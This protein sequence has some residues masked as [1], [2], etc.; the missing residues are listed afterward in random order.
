VGVS[1]RRQGE[2]RKL[3]SSATFGAFRVGPSLLHTAQLPEPNDQPAPGTDV[4]QDAA[5]HEAIPL[6]GVREAGLSDRRV[7]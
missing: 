1:F 7:T 3:T 4:R 2:F 5:I 6:P